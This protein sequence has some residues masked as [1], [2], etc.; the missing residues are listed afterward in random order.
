MHHSFSEL[1]NMTHLFW[2]TLYG[3]THSFIELFK[4]LRHDKAMIPEGACIIHWQ[5]NGGWGRKISAL[6]QVKGL[7]MRCVVKHAVIIQY[8]Q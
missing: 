2:V 3:M 4:P 1:T 7:C 6:V 5:L 8:T